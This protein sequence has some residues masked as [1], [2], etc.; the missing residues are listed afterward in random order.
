MQ[1]SSKS[2]TYN[3]KAITSLVSGIVG[4]AI[5]FL[6]FI[7]NFIG[8]IFTIAT[9]GLG[10]I[11]FLPIVCILGILPPIGWIIAVITGHMA[12]NEIRVTKQDGKGM[13]TAGL[14]MGYIGLIL[15]A[16]VI[17]VTIIIIIFGIT[18]PIASLPILG[19]LYEQFNEFNP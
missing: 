13:A 10:L 19:E 7:F 6:L 8:S 15:I 3:A 4:W 17:I 2:S 5:N 9:L 16:I 12:I 11:C 1:N 18:V 14:I